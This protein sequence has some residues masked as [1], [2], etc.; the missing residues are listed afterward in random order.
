VGGL[1]GADVAA[2]LFRTGRRVPVIVQAEAAECGLACLAM[3]AAAHGRRID[4]PAMRR[5]FVVSL[6]GAT[7]RQLIEIAGRLGM[8][9]RPLR[10]ELDEL[11]ALRTPCLL[12][13]D[14]NHF[15]VLVRCARGVLR[16]HD[17]AHG[18][19]RL[20]L[21]EASAHFTGVALEL[22]PTPRFE[23][24]EERQRIR[25][26]A[27]LRNVSGL[28]RSLAQ[29][30]LLAVA[31]EVCALVAPL[32]MQW[33]VDGAIVSADRDLQALLALGFALLLIVQAAIGT[34]RSWLVV[35]LATHLGLQWSAG[36][37]AHLLR[38]PAAWF[39]RRHVG[40][41]V[42][43]FGSVAAI[44][45]TL[46]TGFVEGAIDGLMAIATL[47]AMLFY[48]AALAAVVVAAALAYALLRWA[49]YGPLRR[50][51]EE[52][53]A[54]DARAASLFMESVRAA[55]PIKLAGHEDERCARW[56]NATVEATNRGL[57]TERLSI[58][59]RLAH[60][61]LA[62]A[63]NIAVVTLGALA[64]IDGGLSVGM[65]FAF[66]AYKTA[67]SARAA[68]LVDKAVQ[69]TMLRLHA[70]RL[71][72]IVLETPEPDGDHPGVRAGVGAPAG[73][74][75]RDHAGA[76]A[77]D[78]ARRD[79][80]GLAIEL[81][82]VSFR[83]GDG[84]PWILRHVCL[85]I[86]PG[87]AVAI[88]GAS[89]C[90]KST[91][92]KILLGLAVPTAGELRIDGVRS[93]RLGARAYRQAIAAVLQ[94]DHLLAGS[95]ADNIA[96]FDERADMRRIACCAKMAAVHDDVVAMPMG[97][98]TLIGDMGSAISGGQKQ[99]ILLARALYRQPRALFLDEATSHLDLATEAGVNTALR[100]LPLTRVIVAHRPQSIGLADRAIV[101]EG[102]RVRRSG[103]ADLDAPARAAHT[104]RDPV[105]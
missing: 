85:A 56:L 83:Y 45:R 65:L 64:V 43:R 74:D 49:A 35:H 32:F 27:V 10:L 25:L 39:E 94:D 88:T 66:V 4:L 92:L 105:Q 104:A 30:A 101:L 17:P 90:G 14:L 47:A 50:A 24:K 38:L 102:G 6:K 16:I 1:P 62:G 99:R 54:L 77:G 31:L 96:L 53:M 22:A 103:R 33:V 52:Q 41:I 84:E 51:S 97:Y 34:A 57:A 36:V 98:A 11:P 78:A 59:F 61:L 73:A 21:A 72:D 13:W 87:E 75:A 40:D 29:L 100:A 18:A 86:A 70:E 89:G 2:R 93:D 60:T 23:R 15:V 80:R 48:S 7:L 63:E 44:R 12:H 91:L 20:R 3:V 42:S 5:R 9:A 46:T 69:F 26:R 71:A 55:A 68:G 19:R 82:D 79:P 81:A 58:G 28:P 76:H 8:T 67:F 95:I 37:F